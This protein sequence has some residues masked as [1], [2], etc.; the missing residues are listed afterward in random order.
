MAR[1][2]GKRLPL[3]TP[4]AETRPEI[5]DKALA[6]FRSAH[7]HG[8][9][10]DQVNRVT[11][12]KALSPM[13]TR[14][15]PV[16]TLIETECLQVW[17]NV[18]SPFLLNNHKD[19]AW[20]AV[21]NCLPTRAFL[22]GR[23]CSRSSKCPRATCHVDEH[24]KHLFW[25]CPHTQTVWGFLRAWLTDLY[26]DPTLNDIMYGELSRYNHKQWERWWAVINSAKDAIWRCRNILVFKKFSMPP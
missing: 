17:R 12:E 24:L 23:R 16:D 7:L 18:N 6:L 13:T 2:F 19:V 25:F 14:L 22:H 4:H 9:A 15:V 26:R 11:V 3:D 1:R 5:Y 21:Q 8:V 20:S 10:V